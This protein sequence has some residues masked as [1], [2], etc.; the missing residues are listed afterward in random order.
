MY[1]HP[2]SDAKTLF[3]GTIIF[4]HSFFCAAMWRPMGHFPGRQKCTRG[5]ALKGNL[6]L[7][8][9][10]GRK[11]SQNRNSPNLF[12]DICVKFTSLEKK[13]TIQMISYWCGKTVST[14]QYTIASVIERSR[15]PWNIDIP[16][17]IVEYGGILWNIAEYCGISELVGCPKNMINQPI[18]S[19]EIKNW[20][21]YP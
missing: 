1:W 11:S 3:K 17:N 15:F 10:L 19:Q 6:T 18:R 9:W 7:S 14:I 12:C 8:I 5:A 20:T 21:P 16:W 2:Y 13:H 4:Y